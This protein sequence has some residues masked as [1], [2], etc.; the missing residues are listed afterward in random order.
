MKNE[1]K[2]VITVENKGDKGNPNHKP[3]GSPEGGQFT[4]GPESGNG[5]NKSNDSFVISYHKE[6]PDNSNLSRNLLMF[7]AQKKEKWTQE[8]LEFQ[9]S[10]SDSISENTIKYYKDLSREDK[11]SLL[12]SSPV[13]YE[14]G[15]LNGMTDEQ[16]N[17]LLI[18]EAVINRRVQLEQQLNIL[19]KQKEKAQEELNNHL[20]QFNIYSVSG[21][22]KN[23]TVY[24][25]DYVQLK[26][27]GSIERKQ[28]YYNKVLNDENAPLNEKI[29]AKQKLKELDEFIE[30]GEEYEKFKMDYM[31]AHAE[32][33]SKI[34]DKETAIREEIQKY[35][36]DSPAVISAKEYQN[37]FIDPNSA[38]SEQRK[39]NAIWFKSESHSKNS[40]DAIKYFGPK[41]NEMRKKMTYDEK[42]MLKRYTSGSSGFNEPLRSIHYVGGKTFSE[43][44]KYGDNFYKA[45]TDLTN[46]ID[47]C[48]WDDDIWVQRGVDSD[49]NMFNKAGTDI[50]MAIEDM[51]EKERDALVGQVFTDSGFYSAG[52]GK[53]TGFADKSLILN[54]YCPKGTKMAYMN[55]PGTGSFSNSIEN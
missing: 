33:T 22:W 48:V 8:A 23:K 39:N 34:I 45:T 3:A 32:E 18:A 15:K 21:V 13:G 11:L 54:T 37:K 38:Y 25:S 50:M 31:L 36:N 42:E 9:N 5:E 20:N 49:T 10:I 1:E 14:K 6:G 27:T 41:S 17:S 24:P 12:Y 44:N 43:N 16:L 28:E 26:G 2:E 55:V 53:G 52:A 35:S 51:T 19:E 46:A 29:K 30:A 4:S 47:K 40:Q 7:I